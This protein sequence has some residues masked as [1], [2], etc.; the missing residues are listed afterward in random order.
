MS[1]AVDPA[2]IELHLAALAEV[3][4]AGHVVTWLDRNAP[5]GER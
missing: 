1:P 2:V 3:V 4:F 5:R